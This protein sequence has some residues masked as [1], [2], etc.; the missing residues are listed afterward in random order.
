MHPS[1][2]FLPRPS[3]STVYIKHT[4]LLAC[5]ALLTLCKPCKVEPPLFTMLEN[6][7]I[8]F[9]NTVKNQKD[10]NI[11]TYRNFY[12]GGGVAIGDIDNDGLPDVYLTA[13]QGS[14]KLYKNK[15]NWQFEDITTTAGVSEADKWSTGVVMVDINA[16]G[17]LDMYVCNAGFQEGMAQANALFINNQDGTFT[18]KAAEY[19]LAD[20]GYTTHAAFF[21]YDMDGDLDCYM[22]NNSFIPV[23]TLNYSNNRD[24]PADKWPVADFLKGGG[25]RLLRNDNG[26]YVDVSKTAGIFQSLIGFG[27]GVTVGDVN[28]DNYPDIYISNDFYERDYLYIN[29][30]NG[31]FSEELEQWTQH[32]SMSSMGADFADVNNDGYP[33]IFVTDMLPGDEYRLK[34]TSSFENYDVQKLKRERGF[35]NQYMQNTLQINNRNNR[36]AETSYFSGVAASDWSWGGLIFDADNDGFSDLFVCNGIY[37][38]VTDQDF[39]DFFAND[40][41]QKMVMTGRKEEVDEVIAKMPSRPI[42]NKAFKNMGNLLFEDKSNAWGFGAATFSNGAAYADLDNDGDLDLIINNVNQPALIYRNEASAKPDNQYLKVQLQGTGA[43]T[44]AIGS[45]IQVYSGSEVLSREVIP[46]RGFQS[47]CDYTVLIGLG[48]KPADSLKV[49]WPNRQVTTLVQPALNQPITLHQKDAGSITQLSKLAAPQPMLQAVNHAL[50]AHTEDEH[51]DF[52]YERNIP[53]KLS[54]QGPALAVGDINLDGLQDIFAGGARGQE[55]VLYLQQPDGSFA[56]SE[57]QVLK[58]FAAWEDVC[59]VIV[60]VNMDGASDIIVGSGGNHV[61]QGSSLLQNRIYLNNGKGNLS[62][63]P[64][65]LPAT[66]HNTAVIAV[67]DWNND[68]APDLFIGSRSVPQQY[69][70]SPQ[71]YFLQNDGK[72]KYTDITQAGGADISKAGMLTGAVWAD[73]TGNGQKELVIAGEWKPIQIF[74]YNG[75]QLDEVK[76]NIAQLKGW[77]QGLHVADIDGDGKADIIA[78]NYGDNFYLQPNP[79]HPVKF[80]LSDFDKNGIAD[81]IITRSRGGKDVPV[82][83]KRELSDQ[84]PALKKKSFLHS[85]YATQDIAALVGKEAMKNALYKEVNTASSYIFWNEGGGQFT[86]EKLPMQVQLSSVH[87]MASSDINGDGRTD[88]LLG[89]NHFAF[90][91]QFSQLDASYGHL[92]LNRGNRKLQ[93]VEARQ[94]GLDVRGQTRHIQLLNIGKDTCYLWMLNNNKPMLYKRKTTEAK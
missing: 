36:F 1:D 30:Q 29:Q 3:G 39:I 13:N 15:G 20:A 2:S 40:I 28:G 63:A 51:N 32:I 83:L 24:L 14:N 85:E 49:I 56:V 48:N 91:P 80:W 45:T 89:G 16:D 90:P 60:D 59:A 93:W 69:G 86:I 22:L 62:L 78:G 4:L 54:T 35:Y 92:L 70:L 18:E 11:F 27:L 57:Q 6:T 50:S 19:G 12:N 82:F 17:W 8:Q 5:C 21:D 9:E 88:L 79:A 58:D 77:W 72:G 53:V 61:A 75:K 46:S 23:N 38:D 10:F 7:G 94:S 74:S 34:T 37:Q 25:D 84:L 52:Y 73:I 66:A 31:T 41:I 44:F 33:D 43:N 42:P 64:A 55:S 47:S 65:A 67:H 76:T 71:H 81:K 87:G 26:T 68:G